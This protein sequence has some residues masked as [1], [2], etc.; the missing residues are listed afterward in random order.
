MTRE[1]P[2]CLVVKAE[3]MMKVPPTQ[4]AV[5]DYMSVGAT[6]LERETNASKCPV[7]AR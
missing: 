2:K 6:V 5:S 3:V 7:V 1:D 4:H